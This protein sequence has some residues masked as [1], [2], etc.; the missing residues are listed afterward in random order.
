MARPKTHG[1]THTPSWRS[2]MNMHTRCTNPNLDR[3]KHYIGKGIQVCDRWKSFEAFYADMGDRPAGMSL[4]RIDRDKNY[5]PGN[6]VW[7]NAKAQ[8]LNRDST[9][10]YE[11]GGQKMC[12]TE[13]AA[14]LGI[15]RY[16][17]KVRVQRWGVDRAVSTPR[18]NYV[19]R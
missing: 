9:V 6:C 11:S 3:A 5:E 15:T 18:R 14:L 12:L 8:A 17:L 2:W 7:A 10:F 13:W 19:R 1:M 16:A 4:E